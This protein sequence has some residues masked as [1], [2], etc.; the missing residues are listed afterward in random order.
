[1]LFGVLTPSGCIRGVSLD[2]VELCKLSLCFGGCL[3]FVGLWFFHN[4]MLHL[5]DLFLEINGCFNYLL[6]IIVLRVI[7][8]INDINKL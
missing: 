8:V 3:H 2:L 6:A 7:Y 1:M 5:L 4:V